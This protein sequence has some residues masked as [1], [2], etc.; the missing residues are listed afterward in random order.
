MKI[1]SYKF[2][3]Y[4]TQTQKVLLAKTFGSVRFVYNR[5]LAIKEA[6]Y[7]KDKKSLSISKLDSE[8]KILKTKEETK[9]LRE[10]NSQSLQS[11]LR[12]LDAAYTGFF[13]KTNGFPKFKSKFDNQRFQNP[14]RT[15]VNFEEGK[16][17]IPKFTEGI[18]TVF[19][20]YFEGKIKTSTVSRSRTGKY[21]IS[22]VVEGGGEEPPIQSPKIESCIGIDLGVKTYATLS[23]GEKFENPKFLKNK[24]KRLKRLSR[25]HSKKKKGSKNRE[26]SRQKLARQHERVSNTREDFIHK[27][28][29]SLV[30]N[31]DYQS[32]AI[33]DLSVTD[34]I[35]NGTKRLSQAIGDCAW[36][37]FR[38][39]LTYK[40]QRAGKSVLVIGRFEPSSKLCTCGQI[41]QELSLKDRNWVCSCGATHDRDLLAAKNIRDFAFSR[42]TT[43]N[44]CVRP[45]RP[46]L[47]RKKKTPV[48][49]PVTGSLK[50]EV[51]FMASVHPAEM[52]LNKT[53]PKI[54]KI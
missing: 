53:S 46:K 9:W 40:A 44:D 17:F 16:V 31:Q 54:G 35:K 15:S 49:I 23:S 29:S 8:I 45:E 25:Q 2:R 36:R 50:Q 47:L 27:L 39:L 20:R 4:P 14:Q 5:I 38:E 1:R 11:S 19:H 41:N 43:K 33:E 24:L 30:E 32:F 21:F 42:E 22:F 51:A 48:E 10:V 34:M 13:R 26:K 12:N 3:I 37:T 28:T 7:E 52:D 6:A 18:K